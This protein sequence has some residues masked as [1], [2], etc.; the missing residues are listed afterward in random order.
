MLFIYNIDYHSKYNVSF[1]NCWQYV[2]G[3]YVFL[4]FLWIKNNEHKVYELSWNLIEITCQLQKDCI[5]KELND[6]KSLLLSLCK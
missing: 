1:Y 5:R 3:L 4:F 2:K 6:K